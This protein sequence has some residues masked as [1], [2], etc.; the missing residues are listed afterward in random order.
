MSVVGYEFLRQH[1]CL[2][3]LPPRRQAV[4]KPVTRI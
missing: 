1:L 3:A 2:A 4:I